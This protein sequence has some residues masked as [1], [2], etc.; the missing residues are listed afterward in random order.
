MSQDV[1]GA[2]LLFPYYNNKIEIV[3]KI[4]ILNFQKV[5][6]SNDE[7]CYFFLKRHEQRSLFDAMRGEGHFLPCYCMDSTNSSILSDISG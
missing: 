6:K 4:I 7:K 3:V 5:D 2:L 1:L